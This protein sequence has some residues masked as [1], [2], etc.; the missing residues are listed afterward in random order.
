[1]YITTVFLVYQF[2]LRGLLE[3][4]GWDKVADELLH[5]LIP[6]LTIIFWCLY[7]TSKPVR[8]AQILPWTIYPLLYLA[9]SLAYGNSTA[10][11]PYPFIDAGQHGMEKVLIN[12]GM[13]VIGFLLM[14]ALFLFIGKS[15]IKR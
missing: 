13:L 2:L 1:V 7:Q 5:T 10:Y 8:Y 3:L 15:V 9:Y 6:I 11:Y 4:H 12:S 14:S